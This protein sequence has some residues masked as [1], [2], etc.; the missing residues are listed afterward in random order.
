MLLYA[1]LGI[2]AAVAYRAALEVAR[3]LC[4]SLDAAR[5]GAPA[6]WV[7]CIPAA[8]AHR[9]VILFSALAAPSQV[10]A[11]ADA[12]AETASE[13]PTPH[14]ARGLALAAAATIALALLVTIW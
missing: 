11:M 12:C 6:A 7:T 5:L 3:A 9:L 8:P 10:G 13:A 14:Q 2:Y 1:F 4:D